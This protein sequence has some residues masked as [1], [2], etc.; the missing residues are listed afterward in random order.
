MTAAIALC[1]AAPAS[2]IRATV[3]PHGLGPTYDGG[4]GIGGVRPLSGPPPWGDTH[5]GA[6]WPRNILYYSGFDCL[7]TQLFQ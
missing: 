1:F 7:Q 4:G 2:S 5:A 3:D 6:A